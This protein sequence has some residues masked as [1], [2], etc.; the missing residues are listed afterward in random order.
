MPLSK[1]RDKERKQQAKVFQPNS[2][3]IP[4]WIAEPN[5][6][7]TGHMNYCSDYDPVKPGDHFDHCP[8]VNPLLRSIE[9]IDGN[10]D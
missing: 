6:Y 4:K 1:K 9:E 10:S 5:K 8:F 3:L 7:L 2:N